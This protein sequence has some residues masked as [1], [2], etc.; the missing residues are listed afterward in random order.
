MLRYV[1]AGL[2]LFVGSCALTK[3]DDETSG[4]CVHSTT[5]QPK[6]ANCLTDTG[7]SS[8]YTYCSDEKIE[9]DCKNL[10]AACSSPTSQATYD[11]TIV[12]YKGKKCA[13]S[14]YTETCTSNSLY[15]ASNQ[16]F[17]PQ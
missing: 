13:E 14:G 2:L 6:L 5:K 12:F 4:I 17:C 11:D 16:T 7:I 8:V 1:F 3:D 10:S 9:K 15:K